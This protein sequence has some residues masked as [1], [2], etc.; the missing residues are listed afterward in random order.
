MPL[1]QRTPCRRTNPTE[2]SINT[3]PLIVT[4]SRGYVASD[5]R[6]HATEGVCRDQTTFGIMPDAK[7][8]MLILMILLLLSR[9]GRFVARRLRWSRLPPLIC[10][11]HV[12]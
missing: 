2:R 3:S 6:F 10:I 7:F 1:S 11:A 8:T 9:E 4:I 12:P 5:T